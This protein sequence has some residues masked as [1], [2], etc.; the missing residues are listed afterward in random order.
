M[1]VLVID[2]GTSG[3]RAAVV[4]PDA[5][6]TSLAYQEALPTSPAPMF[7]E[8]DAAAMATAVPDVA[9]R[10]L[11]AAGPVQAVG[12]ANQ[13]SSTI[14]WDRQTGEPVGPGVS[15]QDLRTA[16]MCL[17]LRQKGFRLA[18][19]ESATKLAFLLD[20]VDPDRSREIGRAHV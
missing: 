16:G 1:S 2:V 10:A 19:N 3:V 9:H 18:P 12:I 11:D 5:E 8:F 17:A 4:D 20:M 6:V 14:V 13:R 15:W 7:V